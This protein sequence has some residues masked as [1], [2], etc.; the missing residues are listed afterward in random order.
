M[1]RA[2]SRRSGFFI[3]MRSRLKLGRGMPGKNDVTV[4]AV[5]AVELRRRR[6]RLPWIYVVYHAGL[7]HPEGAAGRSCA[8][9]RSL[10]VAVAESA[11]RFGDVETSEPRTDSM[12]RNRIRF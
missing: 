11:T 3:D 9:T 7:R 2:R 10:Q 1:S 4:E 8:A 5:R 12:T 6:S